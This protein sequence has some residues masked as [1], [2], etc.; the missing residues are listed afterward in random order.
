M[1]YICAADS[2]IVAAASS[3]TAFTQMFAWPAY[4]PLA[5]QRPH[6]PLPMPPCVPLQLAYQ[7]STQAQLGGLEPFEFAPLP[8]APH[9]RH[10]SNVPSAWGPLGAGAPA[11][12]AAAAAAAA[13]AHR[14][15]LLEEEESAGM[16]A[17]LQQAAQAAAPQRQEE[18]QD[19]AAGWEQYDRAHPVPG[20]PTVQHDGRLGVRQS[21][22]DLEPLPDG[23]LG[24]EQQLGGSPC[25]GSH[26]RSSSGGSGS[27]GGDGSSR[28]AHSSGEQSGASLPLD[29]SALAC[30]SGSGEEQAAE[31][32]APAHFDPLG[33]VP[34]PESA[35]QEEQPAKEQQQQQQGWAGDL[36]SLG[37][38][39][40]GAPGNQAAT[41]SSAAVRSQLEDLLL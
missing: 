4:K 6:L 20:V 13:M 2:S 31:P 37:E 26:Q 29:R 14:L 40:G 30:S 24:Y 18:Q 11:A 17:S 12:D 27:L 21:L 36:L 25:G 15:P 9:S 3:Y 16:A 1:F 8:P 41:S 32:A 10:S 35:S 34:H 22:M 19:G 33:A 5:F 38:H 28:L 39:G 7:D 23:E